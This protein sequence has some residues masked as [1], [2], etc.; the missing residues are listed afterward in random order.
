LLL[1][2]ESKGLLFTLEHREALHCE[3]LKNLI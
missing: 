1:D 3:R 2:L